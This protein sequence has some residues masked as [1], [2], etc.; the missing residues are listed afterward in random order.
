MEEIFGDYHCYVGE[1][2]LK[3][4]PCTGTEAPYMPYSL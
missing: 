2:E 1:G 3:V 4:H